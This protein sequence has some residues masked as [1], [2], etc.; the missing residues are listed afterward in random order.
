MRLSKAMLCTDGALASQ[1]DATQAHLHSYTVQL[2]L[3]KRLTHHLPSSSLPNNAYSC[4]TGHSYL[5]HSSHYP[6]RTGDYRYSDPD[7]HHNHLLHP[8]KPILLPH[9]FTPHSSLLH[10]LTPSTLTY[11]SPYPLTLSLIYPLTPSPLHPLTPSPQFPSFIYL[12]TRVPPH[13]FT[14][15]S[16]PSLFTPSLLHSFTLGL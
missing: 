8:G 12:L 3:W 14:L 11:L 1:T 6:G 2:I 5:G 9:S 16:Y 7:H 10:P 4:T 13:S 15:H